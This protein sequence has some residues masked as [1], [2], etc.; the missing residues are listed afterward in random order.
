MLEIYNPATDKHL[1]T[2]ENDSKKEIADKFAK[3][4]AALSQWSQTSLET[5][6]T[7]IKKFRSAVVEQKNTLAR[8]LTNEM[9]KPISQSTQELN[10]LL[11]RIDFFL[12]ETPRVL[13]I[14]V[15]SDSAAT[16]TEKISKEPLGVIANISAWNYPYFVGSN[17]F[18]P[19]LLTGNTVLYKPS[20]FASITGT[21]ITQL[22]HDSG[23]PEDVF[24]LVVGDGKVGEELLKLPF[25]GVFFTG[26]Y[27]TGKK[28]NRAVSEHF[29][30]VQLELG[31][32]DPF[33]VC[34]DV[35]IKTAAAGLADG[36]FYNNGQSCC[37]VERIYVHDSIYETFCTHFVE[38]VK[39]FVIGDPL[40]EKTYIGP[41]TQPAQIK[42]LQSQVADAI[43]KGAKLVCGGKA[44]ARAGNYFEPTVLTDVTHEMNVMMEE[45]FGP[46][47]GIQSVKDDLHAIQLMNDTAYGLTAGVYTLKKERAESILKQLNAGSVYWNVCDRVSP[48]LPWS[49]RGNSGMGCTLS[50]Y[51]IETFL[52]LKA[53]HL[54]A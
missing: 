23:I 11:T 27:A 1:L 5:R 54:K 10:G 37:S 8:I 25:D 22:L 29:T 35:E 13:E 9:G 4:K 19:A 34:D 15:V 28:I 45:S 30:K 31:G 40:N 42:F 14:E 7:A 36:A 24:V 46:I 21:A 51:G 49:G 17:V 3:A 52:K 53:W 38:E 16:V 12:E 44:M 41:L 33:Y 39:K 32:K 6:L 26:S 20:E 2:I 43:A 48:K 18:I 50:H 47:I